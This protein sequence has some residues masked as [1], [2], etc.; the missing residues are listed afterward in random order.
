[1]ARWAK[2]AMYGSGT[3]VPLMAQTA[4]R[5]GLA[6]SAV[7]PGSDPS[8]TCAPRAGSTT[9]RRARATTSVFVSRVSL[10]PRLMHC[11]SWPEQDGCCGS[12]GRLLFDLWFF[13][14]SCGEVESPP[15]ANLAQRFRI[16]L[17]DR[18]GHELVDAASGVGPSWRKLVANC[19]KKPLRVCRPVRLAGISLLLPAILAAIEVIGCGHALRWANVLTTLPLSRSMAIDAA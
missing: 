8:S 5:P 9:T 6:R 14:F 7:A 15:Q 13:A 10:N 11:F 16:L 17:P 4:R 19:G 3:R 1:M 18:G 2:A 12:A